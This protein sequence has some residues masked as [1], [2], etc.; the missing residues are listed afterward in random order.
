MATH[1]RT[2]F[3]SSPLP[4]LTVLLASF[5]C[6]NNLQKEGSDGTS[7]DGPEC[8][9][10]LLWVDADLDGF[11]DTDRPEEACVNTPGH[12]SMSGDCDDSN[13]N[14]HPAAPE[15]C[16]G[17]DDDCDNAVDMGLLIEVWS[18]LDGDSFGDPDSYE[19]VCVAEAHHVRD[20]TDCNDD[21]PAVYPGAEEVCDGVDQDCDGAVDEEAVDR[22]WVFADADMDGLGDAADS[23]LACEDTEGVAFNGW[24]CDDTDPTTPVVV[25]AGST[26]AAGTFAEPLG[27]IQAGVDAALAGSG[28]R[29]VAVLGGLYNETLD[30]SAGEVWVEGVEGA[31]RTVVDGYGLDRPVLTLGAENQSGTVVQGLTLTQGSPHIY[32]DERS[33][34]GQRQDWVYHLGAGVYSFGARATLRGVHITDNI[35]VDSELEPYVDAEGRTVTI[36]WYGYGGGVYADG[37]TLVL[38]DCRIEG[39]Q[40]DRGGGVYSKST[41]VVLHTEFWNNTATDLGGGLV[42]RDAIATV[43]NST[44]IGNEAE[45]GAA[46]YAKDATLLMSQITFYEDVLTDVDGAVVSVDLVRGL[47]SNLILSTVE[48]LGLRV[49]D[50]DSDVEVEGVLFYGLTTPHESGARGLKVYGSIV[51]EDPMFLVVSDDGNPTNDDLHLEDDSPAKDAGMGGRDVDGSAADLGAYGGAYGG[52]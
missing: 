43:E 1:P 40:A 26:G 19:Q 36:G 10:A 37:G 50:I 41:L 18:D 20:S 48:P 35:I 39:N 29:C 9:K 2:N 38:E 17:I 46:L 8:A 3:L 5:G 44:F 31:D 15:V 6:S 34:A 27:S 52:W 30:L 28:E 7:S 12:S 11:G 42:V 25:D 13:P 22:V 51:D 14:V 45:D 21:N 33:F 32:T 47:W 4:Y 49:V 16:N 23:F 24:D